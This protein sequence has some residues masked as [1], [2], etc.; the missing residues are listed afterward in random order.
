MHFGTYDILSGLPG[1]KKVWEKVRET[2]S[3]L[4]GLPLGRHD[5]V[6]GVMYVNVEEYLSRD[7]ALL[8]PEIH[9]RYIDVQ[10]VLS[11]MELVRCY[12]PQELV[13]DTPYDEERDLGFYK[14][15]AVACQ[16]GILD[17]GHIAVIPPYEAHASQMWVFA[18]ESL[19]IRK[20]VVKVAVNAVMEN[21]V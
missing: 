18:G 8:R 4:P 2:L 17:P 13:V 21:W 9:H 5:I 14:A 6:P 16:S 12:L 11:G 1:D 10:T 3:S 15:G 19:S 7:P 20:A